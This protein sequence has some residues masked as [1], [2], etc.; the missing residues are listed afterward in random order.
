MANKKTKLSLPTEAQVAK[1][2]MLD[3]LLESLEGD[4]AELSK[5]KPNEQ[6]N[7]YKVKL[8]NN[9]L[10]QIQ[11]LLRDEPTIEFLKTLDNDTMPSYSDAVLTIGQFTAAMVQFK[12]KHYGYLEDEDEL[13]EDDEVHNYRWFT[14][15][16][17]R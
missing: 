7:D 12:E 5:K 2:E 17:P 10:L 11:E 6:L 4:I 8:V 13:A 16:N 1:F 15:E 14:K 9:V 3:K